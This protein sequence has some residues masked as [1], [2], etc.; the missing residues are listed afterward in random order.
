MINGTRFQDRYAF[1][2]YSVFC[3]ISHTFIFSEIS[4]PLFAFPGCENENSLFKCLFCQMCCL[5][6][7]HKES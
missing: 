7:K 6:L 4:R 3:I 5:T 1:P 2:V